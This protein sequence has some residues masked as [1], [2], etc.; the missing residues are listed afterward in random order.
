M[1]ILRRKQQV[2]R[3]RVVKYLESQCDMFTAVKEEQT[4]EQQQQQQQQQQQVMRKE[5][6]GEG[7][8]K[9]AGTEGGEVKDPSVMEVEQPLGGKQ[10]DLLGEEETKE[11]VHEEL[12]PSQP[13]FSLKDHLKPFLGLLEEIV[14][15]T[16]VG[17]IRLYFENRF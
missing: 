9:E 12:L 5:Q 15:I 4:R 14:G 6:E 17:N 8:G 13:S 7:K 11:N 16:Q 1:P 3:Q 2:Y 10:I